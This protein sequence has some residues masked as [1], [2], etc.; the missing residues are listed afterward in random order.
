MEQLVKF[1]GR[2]DEKVQQFLKVGKISAGWLVEQVG[3]KGEQIGLAK[4]SDVH[5]NFIVNLKGATAADVHALIE[6]IKDRVYT[7]YGIELEEEIAML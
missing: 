2:D 6:K 4:I 5:G 3:M 1:F 7:T